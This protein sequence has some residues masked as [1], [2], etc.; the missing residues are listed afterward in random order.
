MCDVLLELAVDELD[1]EGPMNLV[2]CR[3]SQSATNFLC[4]QPKFR[5]TNWNR[6]I[7]CWFDRNYNRSTVVLDEWNLFALM[8]AVVAGRT[9]Y[10]K[11]GLMNP[12][13]I[14]ALPE[15]T[16]IGIG[17]VFVAAEMMMMMMMRM[18]RDQ[19]KKQKSKNSITQKEYK[20]KQQKLFNRIT[21]ITIK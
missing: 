1:T 11:K 20:K 4:F 7:D 16:V 8:A 9:K 19:M 2:Y 15:R 21:P 14:A 17:L 13:R 3:S 18:I 12:K 5:L 10:P 6:Q